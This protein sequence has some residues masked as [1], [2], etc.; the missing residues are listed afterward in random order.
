MDVG[1][2]AGGVA[3]AGARCA[4]EAE[5]V[6]VVDHQDCPGFRGDLAKL[7]QGGKIAIH[8]EE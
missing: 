8:A 3:V 5:R 6:R 2:N 1:T 7:G 4:M